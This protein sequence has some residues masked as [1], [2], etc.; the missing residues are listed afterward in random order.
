MT[1]ERE[2]PLTPYSKD[3]PEALT[4]D[5]EG[6]LR[7]RDEERVSST[8]AKSPVFALLILALLLVAVIISIVIGIQ[9]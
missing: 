6:N 4:L 2:A 5:N 9:R 8:T 7:S 1:S 3:A